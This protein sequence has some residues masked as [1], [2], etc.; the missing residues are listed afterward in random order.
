MVTAVGA[1]TRQIK[2]GA[3][4]PSLTGTAGCSR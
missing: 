1:G 3:H 2:I 4:D